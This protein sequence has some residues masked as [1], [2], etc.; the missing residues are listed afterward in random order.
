M[1]EWVQ[2][3]GRIILTGGRTEELCPPQ[4]SH[5]MIWDRTRVFV[6]RDRRLTASAM[7]QPLKICLWCRAKNTGGGGGGGRQ[8]DAGSGGATPTAAQQ[9]TE[10]LQT[11]I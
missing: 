11:V 4:I 1:N 9:H 10:T 3:I 2:S 8:G 6:A 5:R 7:A